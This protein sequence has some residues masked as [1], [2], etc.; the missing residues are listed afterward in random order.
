[1]RL[2]NPAGP[3]AT[4]RIMSVADRNASGDA[5]ASA[6]QEYERRAFARRR[7]VRER[8]GPVGSV[9]AAL[10]GEPR[11]IHAWKQGAEG[12]AATARALDHHLRRTHV[13]RAAAAK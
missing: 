13:E 11:N 5:G 8:Y 1:M 6:E 4:V 2:G 10:A 7:R 3:R 9:I 12:E